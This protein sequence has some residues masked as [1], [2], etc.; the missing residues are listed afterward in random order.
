MGS[1]FNLSFRNGFVAASFLLFA[2]AIIAGKLN[3]QSPIEFLTADRYGTGLNTIQTKFADLDGDGR[4]DLVTVNGGQLN[5]F[6][7]MTIRYGTGD[8]SN[9]FGPAVVTWMPINGHTLAIGDLNGDQRP[10]IVVGSWYF[11]RLATVYNLGNRAFSLPYHSSPPVASVTTPQTLVVFAGQ[12][13]DLGIGDF[14]GN[15][16]NEVVALQG[17]VNQRLL[18]LR[19]DIDGA[20]H[21]VETLYSAEMDNS[22]EREIAVGDLNGDGRDDVVFA[23]GGPFRDRTVSFVYGRPSGQAMAIVPG[24]LVMSKMVGVDIADLDRDGDNDLTV[25][26]TSVPVGLSS[27]QVWLNDGNAGFTPLPKIEL[28]QP[29]FLHGI[30]SADYNGD[31]KRDLSLL[32]RGPL[33]EGVLVMVTHGNGDGT[34]GEPKYYATAPSSDIASVDVDLDSQVDIV[35]MSDALLQTD[36]EET[37][38]VSNNAANVLL[39]KQ[40]L[41]FRAPAVAPGGGGFLSASD[42]NRDGKLDLVSSWSYHDRYMSPLEVVLNDG[43]RGVMTPVSYPVADNLYGVG[44]GDFNGDGNV[45]AV[46]THRSNS[47]VIAM[48]SGD[49]T[50]ALGSRIITQHSSGIQRLLVLDTN[51]DGRD[52]LFITDELGRALIMLANA[53]GTFTPA[54]ETPSFATPLTPDL[55]QKVDID[56]DNNDDILAAVG[57]DFR[58]LRGDGQ[59]RF[60]EIASAVVAERAVTG[61]CN[62]DGKIDLVGMVP[63][64]ETVPP[65]ETGRAVRCFL[66]NGLGGF[67]PGFK[68][69]IPNL[70]HEN[71]ADMVLADFDLDGYDDVAIIMIDNIFGNLVI[72]PS[73]GN[74]WGQPSFPAAGP[75]SRKLIA[76]DFDGDG[77]YDLGYSGENSRG[78]LYNTTLLPPRRISGRVN[79]PI[80]IAVRNA[81]VHLIGEDEVV[82]TT[83]T[84]SF[85]T[86]SFDS[87]PAGSYVLTVSSKRYRFAPKSVQLAVDLL[88]VDFIGLE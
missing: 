69:V 21:V 20:L 63:A 15:G 11:N 24:P 25:A 39:N 28:A 80:G 75:A 26:F 44:V 67:T 12:F 37:E 23:G 41:G 47:R 9:A 49:G 56:S 73:R 42:L 87:V 77:R 64:D 38:G 36:Y 86:Y 65:N 34:F 74:A 79:N 35:T 4:T 10:D 7:T 70:S 51:S 18:F 1:I 6:P 31:R 5:P 16:T 59:G 60:T 54:P 62:G 32:L 85:G 43:Q 57:S 66:G 55:L 17:Q 29:L 33:L 81:A 45:D 46:T 58:I 22:H 72:L 83:Y 52:D 27:F 40:P 48:Y 14:D 78:V 30:S 68:A 53:N 13:F 61:D 8:A 76:A 82:R 88:D 50:G 71:V 84:S 3:A 19:A 2:F